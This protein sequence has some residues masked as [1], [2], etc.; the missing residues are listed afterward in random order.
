MHLAP[1][2]EGAGIYLGDPLLLEWAAEWALGP[3]PAGMTYVI[4][5]FG[6]AA[7]F[8][9]FVT[10]LNLIPIGQ[11]DGGHVMYALFRRRAWTVSRVGWW[12]CVALVYWSPSWIL[13]AVLLRLLG[14][15]HPPTLDDTEPIGPGRGVVAL[16][17]LAVFAAC[18]IP[19]PVAGSWES[20]GEL[21]G[22]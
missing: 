14:R 22:F 10:A 21:L 19:E 18:F 6:T 2:R 4:G 9:L 5:P 15:R 12:L 13:W 7:W 20:I 3:A 17:G 8:G 1:L 16:L 11:L